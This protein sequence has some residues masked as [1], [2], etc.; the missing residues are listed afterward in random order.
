M[1]V[2]RTTYIDAHN[3]LTTKGRYFAGVSTALYAEK[4]EKMRRKNIK[5]EFLFLFFV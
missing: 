1:L 4:H 5:W 3:A 2:K